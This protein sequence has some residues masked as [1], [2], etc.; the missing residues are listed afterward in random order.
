VKEALP[1]LSLA[2]VIASLFLSLWIANRAGSW[3]NSD[4]LRAIQAKQVATDVHIS[5]EL[6][7]VE[8]RQSGTDARLSVV[9]SQV[10]SEVAHLKGVAQRLE[11]AVA[12]MEGFFMRPPNG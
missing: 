9:E 7:K 10:E 8:L 2:F 4:E 12:R 11:S 1:Y 5:D 3:R 6:R